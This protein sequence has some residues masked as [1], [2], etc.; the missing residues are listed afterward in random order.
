VAAAGLL[1]RNL[2]KRITC[3]YKSRIEKRGKQGRGKCA[4]REGDV[5][6][7]LAE[8]GCCGVFPEGKRKK[9]PVRN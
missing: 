2:K 6:Y 9:G 7:F 1:E 8:G 4:K 5:S 3:Q